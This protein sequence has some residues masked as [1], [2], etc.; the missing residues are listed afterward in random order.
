MSSTATLAP[1]T[2]ARRTRQSDNSEFL[3]SGQVMAR[4][5]GVSHMWIVRRM[6]T[7]GFPR[8]T[9]FGRLRFWRRTE[10]EAWE[11]SKATKAM[12]RQST[13]VSTS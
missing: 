9:Y 2:I 7:D 11:D 13:G 4:Y 10:V 8:P 5:G 6:K 12:L 3:T 1:S